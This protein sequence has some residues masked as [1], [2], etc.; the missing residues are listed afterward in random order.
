VAVP[1]REATAY[2][3]PEVVRAP[4]RPRVLHGPLALTAGVYLA[5]SLAL[6]HRLLPQLTTSTAGWNSS[7]SYQFVWWLRWLPWSLVHGQNPLFTS[8]FHAPFG[9][10]GM[11]NT[12]VP[13]LATFFAPVTLTAGPIAAYN[14]AVVLGPVVSGLAL[15]LALGVWV[16]RWWPRAVAGL[17]YGFSPFA[18]AHTSVGHLNLLWAVL[19]PVL[20]WVVHALLV[21][22]DPRPWRIGALAGLAF[23]CRRGSTR[24]PSPCPRSSSS[25]W[26]WCWRCGGRLRRCGAFPWCSGES[27]PAWPPTRCSAPTRSTCCSRRPAGR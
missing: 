2:A 15:A 7:D 27:W 22:P 17:L 8:Y 14:V 25:W 18:I 20:L 1:L 3:K 5:A 26:R 13:V 23:A 6:H 4:S 24:R 19:P 16:E 10:N 12:P 9:V 11:W 21:A